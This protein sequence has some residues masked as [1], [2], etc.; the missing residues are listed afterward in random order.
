MKVNKNDGGPVCLQLC[1][2]RR[3]TGGQKT[4]EG[5]LVGL[6]VKFCERLAR[7]FCFRCVFFCFVFLPVQFDSFGFCILMFVFKHG[8]LVNEHEGE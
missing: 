3:S 2:N 7:L 8:D 4:E 6:T 1:P 5:F